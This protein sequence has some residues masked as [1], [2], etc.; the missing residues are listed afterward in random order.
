MSILSPCCCGYCSSNRGED[1]ADSSSNKRINVRVPRLAFRTWVARPP[2]APFCFLLSQSLFSPLPLSAFQ[3]FV[4][5]ALNP[6]PSTLNLH[7]HPPPSADRH[8][9]GPEAPPA[10]GRECR[11]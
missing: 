5:P 2:K 3:L 11:K 7:N 1:Q 9:L 4:D 10:T 6:P 8:H